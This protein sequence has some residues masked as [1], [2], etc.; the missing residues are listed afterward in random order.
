MKKAIKYLFGLLIIAGLTGCASVPEEEMI[1]KKNLAQDVRDEIEFGRHMAAKLLGH[2]GKFEKYPEAL[3]YV[4]L[5]GRSLAKKSGRPELPFHFGILDSKQVN[6]F[7]TPGGYIFVTKGL[8]KQIKTESELAVVLGHEIAHINEKHMYKE[9]APEKKVSTSE[10][11]VRMMSRGG[12]DISQGLSKAVSKG[13]AM[14]LEKGMGAEKEREAD[15][16]GLI[17]AVSAGYNPNDFTNFLKRLNKNKKKLVLDKNAPPFG[18]RI[19]FVKKTLS[20]NGLDNN[21]VADGKA[22]DERFKAAFAKF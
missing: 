20:T 17:Y 21:L 7:A 8:L 6:A 9:V 2:F 15:E 5:V 12:G 1:F 4:N 14:L 13:M 11:V 16:A 18:S 22:L 10:T 19:A 3:S